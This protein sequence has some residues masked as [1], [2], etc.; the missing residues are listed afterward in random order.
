MPQPKEED[1]SKEFTKDWVTKKSRL[2]KRVLSPFVGFPGVRGLEI[3]SYEGRSACWFLDN[4][5]TGEGAVLHCV[6]VWQKSPQTPKPHKAEKRFRGN[7]AEY[8]ERL[9]V[10]KCL[11]S[12]FAVKMLHQGSRELFDFIYLD[13]THEASELISDLVLTWEL[14]KPGGVLICDDYKLRQK[15]ITHVHPS[16]AID[17]FLACHQDWIDVHSGYQRVVAK[18]RKPNSGHLRMDAVEGKKDNCSLSRESISLDR[19]VVSRLI[20]DSSNIKTQ[21]FE[22]TLT[23]NVAPPSSL[24]NCASGIEI[25][26]RKDVS[27]VVTCQAQ[28][29]HLKKTI[30]AQLS[31]GA[32]EYILV[33]YE[34]PELSGDW[35]EEFF[36]RE[37]KVVRAAALD[38]PKLNLSHARNCGAT[39]AKG[40]V[41]VFIDADVVPQEGWLVRVCNLFNQDSIPALVRLQ[42]H[43]TNVS[44][45]RTCAV[46][47]GIWHDVRGYREAFEHCGYADLDFYN[48][49]ESLAP[50][51]EY[52]GALLDVIGQE[53]TVSNG[54][55]KG[56]RNDRSQNGKDKV[57]LLWESKVNPEGWGLVSPYEQGIV[58]ATDENF[59]PGLKMLVESIRDSNDIPFR[60]IDLGMSDHQKRWCYD[61]GV[62][63]IDGVRIVDQM[64][65]V[66]EGVSKYRPIRRFASLWAKPWLISLSPFRDTIWIDSDAVVLR[67]LT[68]LFDRLKSGI[69]AIADGNYPAGSLNSEK[70]YE[71]L[72]VPR[73]TD[74]YIN[75]GVIGLR[76]D[77][78][79]EFLEAWKYCVTQAG[80]REEVRDAVAWHDQGAALWAIHK[81]ERT[82]Q[83]NYE[84]TWNHPPHGYSSEQLKE[85][86]RYRK[87]H[88][89]KDLQADHC[90]AGIVHYMSAPKLWELVSSGRAIIAAMA[91]TGATMLEAAL[92]SHPQ[93][94]WLHELNN[95][96]AVLRRHGKKSLDD[97]SAEQQLHFFE[98]AGWNEPM[99]DE[100]VVGFKFKLAEG[101]GGERAMSLDRRIK[102]IL[103]SRRN[104][105]EQ[106]MSR[107]V[108]LAL[109]H[110]DSR[111]RRPPG[112]LPAYTID[113]GW[114]EG[115]FR[116]IEQIYKGACEEFDEHPMLEVNYEELTGVDAGHHWHRITEFLE[117]DSLPWNPP[118]IKQETRSLAEV[119]LNYATLRE[120]FAGTQ[121]EWMFRETERAGAS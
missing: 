29:E 20:S 39:V 23:G 120:S 81:T 54:Q 30:N 58:T 53:N 46:R 98:Q 41:L 21:K 113:P 62:N 42:T 17:A 85:R 26:T 3:G 87:G 94:R 15:D 97:L 57:T 10:H 77:R 93:A 48:R 47:S 86:K 16:V 12:E 106:V 22:N 5:L 64:A 68:E 27:L 28:L 72:P 74:H 76:M 31:Q 55:F 119:I 105:L 90:K 116:Y 52:D 82:D 44:K 88:W 107:Q 114:L 59:F 67:P 121:W 7:T 56:N 14:L 2:W 13:S 117:I 102:V 91:R 33:D 19:P 65:T 109:R 111:E 6:D 75:S 18:K 1:R 71:L 8:G 60:C 79:R 32:G 95:S 63:L 73:L 89:L 70:L 110:Y 51:I 50:S 84:L 104:M 11:S 49:V 108:A 61:C 66:F 100:K 9:V 4:V 35:A 78:D 38:P 80:I 40:K 92:D 96:L 37:V 103:L 45:R 25:I 99:Q 43:E 101:T 24:T 34:C 112:I 115:Q 36:G 83:I 118:T 69:V